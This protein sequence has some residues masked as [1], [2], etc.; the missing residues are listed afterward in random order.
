MKFS[1][2]TP[3]YNSAA[4]IRDTFESV[5]NQT[6]TDYEYIVVDGGSKDSTLDIIKE[7][8]PKFNGRMRWISEPD[9]GIYDAVA[10]GFRMSSGEI[11][12]WLGS[13]D[14]LFSTAFATVNEIYEKFPQ[15]SWLIAEICLVSEKNV[16][17]DA[18]H[19]MTWSYRHFIAGAA[20]YVQQ[21]GSFFK[22]SLWEQ[23]GG[24]FSS[25]RWA[26]DYEL[27]L[28]FSKL[29]TCYAV[30][31]LT[32]AFRMRSAGQAS[33]ENAKA[34]T[35]EAMQAIKEHLKEENIF[36][37]LWFRLLRVVYSIPKIK[38]IILLAEKRFKIPEAAFVF[39]RTSQSWILY[40]DYVKLCKSR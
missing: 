27:W 30:S 34:Y 40:K 17:F 13:D 33:Y 22:R 9:N 18:V 26:S 4:T 37:R 38:N 16:F 35:Q 21:E 5:L 8:E 39:D 31:A 14:L 1:I 20:F 19:S 23:A 10:K 7:Y 11:L 28:R 25:L 15:V 29:T 32:A 12:T 6:F 24:K 3:C 2:I 36:R